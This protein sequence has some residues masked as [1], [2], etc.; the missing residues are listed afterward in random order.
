[1][2]LVDGRISTPQ[3]RANV[4]STNPI[5]DAPLSTIGSVDVL[6]PFAPFT[7]ARSLSN[8]EGSVRVPCSCSNGS[9]LSDMTTDSVVVVLLPC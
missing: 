9:V 6:V 1:M 8:A 5:P 2:R 3:R 4:V 7:L